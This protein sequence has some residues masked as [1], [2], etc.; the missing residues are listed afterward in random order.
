[1]LSDEEGTW[2]GVGGTGVV[3]LSVSIKL[4]LKSRVL[5]IKLVLIARGGVE[6]SEIH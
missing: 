3:G 4:F 2:E 1:M 5:G 6:V